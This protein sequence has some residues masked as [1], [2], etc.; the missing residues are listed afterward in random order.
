MASSQNSKEATRRPV[1]WEHGRIYISPK[2]MGK[3]GQ[4]E[5]DSCQNVGAFQNVLLF[6]SVYSSAF[7]ADGAYIL[8]PLPR[9]LLPSHSS[10]SHEWQLIPPIWRP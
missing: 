2:Q 8:S 6:S 5:A 10:I 1:T 7:L 4:K 3:G 9:L